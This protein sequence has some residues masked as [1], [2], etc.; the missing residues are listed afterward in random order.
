MAKK[1][2][3]GGGEGMKHSEII[4]NLNII[5][6]YIEGLIDD[7]K[8]EKKRQKPRRDCIEGLI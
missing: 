3:E 2:I 7:L 4:R 6:G 1:N 5:K 8:Q